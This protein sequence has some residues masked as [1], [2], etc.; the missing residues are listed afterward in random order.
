MPMSRFYHRVDKDG[1]PVRKYDCQAEVWK[2]PSG[3][4][5]AAEFAIIAAARLVVMNLVMRD[6]HGLVGCCEFVEESQKALLFIALC[7][8]VRI[9]VTLRN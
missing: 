4:L 3:L 7:S 5:H 6:T 2:L 9:Q 8:P 1:K